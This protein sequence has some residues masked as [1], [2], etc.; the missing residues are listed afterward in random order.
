MAT[1]TIEIPDQLADRINDKKEQ[2]SKIIELGLNKL[3]PSG[4]QLYGEVI[5]FLSKGPTATQIKEF[6]PSVE[7]Q[8]RIENLLE[9]N[10]KGE[11][12]A[13]ESAELDQI[14]A[15]NHFMTLIKS[16]A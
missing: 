14:Q 6:S 4:S 8:E 11:L 1:L 9:K 10:R 5:S 13:E 3:S 2:L 7:A 12:A 15:L 16:K